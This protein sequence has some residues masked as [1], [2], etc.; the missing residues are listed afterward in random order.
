MND[1]KKCAQSNVQKYF[2][3]VCLASVFKKKT[4]AAVNEWFANFITVCSEQ[5]MDDKGVVE[6]A[7]NTLLAGVEKNDEE[8]VEETMQEHD[9][10]ENEAKDD[11]QI[12][13]VQ[14]YKR[15]R[16]YQMCSKILE[17]Y[18]SLSDTDTMRKTDNLLFN[19]D[20][21]IIMLK[22]ICLIYHYGQI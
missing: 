8:L 22:N 12:G 15:S 1:T 18:Q 21:V 6:K 19:R 11:E 2:I 10:N 3:N 9:S 20:I 13:H 16:F 7:K 4:L 17:N 14:L 5:C